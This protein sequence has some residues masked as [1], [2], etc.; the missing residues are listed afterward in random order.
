LARGVK[1]ASAVA[2]AA[3]VI[4]VCVF[5]FAVVVVVVV[6][7]VVVVVVVVVAVVVVVVDVVGAGA[8][9]GA[10]GHGR[11]SGIGK[12]MRKEKRGGWEHMS[13]KKITKWEEILMS[14]ATF[15]SEDDRERLKIMGPVCVR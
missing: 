9:A 1:A 10:V 12:R 6:A 11:W 4:V 8:G 13:S 15:F 5:V 2:A 7:V 3:V 14:P